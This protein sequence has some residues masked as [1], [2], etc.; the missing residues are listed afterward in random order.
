MPGEPA[1]PAAGEEQVQRAVGTV[2]VLHSH[3]EPEPV[4]QPPGQARRS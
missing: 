3:G 2:C 1:S 4:G